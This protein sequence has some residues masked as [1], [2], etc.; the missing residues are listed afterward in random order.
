ME[1]APFSPKRVRGIAVGAGDGGEGGA[2]TFRE[3]E[4][5][6]LVFFVFFS[7]ALFGEALGGG[8]GYGC[9]CFG[10]WGGGGGGFGSGG[11]VDGGGGGSG[12]GVGEGAEFDVGGFFVVVVVVEWVVYEGFG[13]WRH[14]VC[15]W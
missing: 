6:Q 1:E 8:L 5:A 12:G 3:G 2:A 13:E 14:A 7:S 11:F 4:F 9:C 10:G 15:C